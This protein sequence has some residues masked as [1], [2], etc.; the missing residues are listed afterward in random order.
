MFVP[1]LIKEE[2][3][4]GG[5][6]KLGAFMGLFL[7]GYVLIA[8]FLGSLI[9]ATAGIV[10]ILLGKLKR[11]DSLPFGPFLALGA[12]VTLFFGPQICYF[13]HSLWI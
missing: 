13:Y 3:M 2:W 11:K 5:D 7:G 4:G 1:A 6:V 10:L 12:V 8:L 9:A